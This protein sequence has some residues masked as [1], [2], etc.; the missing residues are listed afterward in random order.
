ME[1]NSQEIIKSHNTLLIIISISCLGCSLEGISQGWEMWVPPLL[2][3]AVIAAWWMHITQRGQVRSRENYYLYLSIFMGFFHGIHTDSFF[4]VVVVSSLLMGTFTLLKRVIYLRIILAEYVIVII[5]QIIMAAVTGNTIFDSLTISRLALHSGSILCIYSVLKKML[6]KSISDREEINKRDLD[7][8]A[9][10]HDMEDFL[11]NISH[12][13]R[14]PVNV[15]N[16]LSGLI[17]NREKR[18]DVKSIRNAGLRLARQIEDIQDYSEIQRKDLKIE[19]EKYMITSVLNDILSNYNDMEKI[20]KLDFVVDLDPIVPAAMRGDVNK[21]RK[22]IEHLLDNAFKFTKRGGVRLRISAIRKDYGVNLLIEVSDT[23]I[24]MSNK[25]IESVSNGL[26]QADKKRTRSTGGIGLGLSIVYGMIRNMDGFVRI[27][28]G[29]GKGTIVRISV[30]QEVVDSSPCMSV[31]TN[32]FLNVAYYT[33]PGTYR[34]AYMG[35]FYSDMARNLASGLR[36]NLYSAINLD[37]LKKLLSKGNITHVFMGANE[38]AKDA[39]YFD[40][41]AKGKVKV[42]I[43]APRDFKVSSDSNVITM[44]LPL[45]GYQIVQILNGEIDRG[46]ISYEAEI[47]KPVL[48]GVRALVVDDEPMNLVVAMGLLRE[49]K[50]LVDTAE[51][52][53]ESIE[54]FSN[55]DYD[56]ILMDHMMPEM[57]G[58]EAMKKI[59]SIAEQENRKVKLIAFTANAVSG[60]REMFMQE[61]FDGFISK[62]IKVHDFERVMAHVMSEKRSG[63][64]GGAR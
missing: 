40:E 29:K 52:G 25:D 20:H 39:G 42:A 7:R 43:S 6:Q 30:F 8:K 18:E 48:E 34:E 50:M 57:D 16:G 59:R 41:L 14:T 1:D 46:I 21:I 31:N 56:V 17:L 51:S 2:A 49:Y 24:G 5:I 47:E 28:S 63:W 26:Y 54:K 35:A 44:S 61:G 3:L 27:E 23:G 11:V 64:K 22:I 9:Y 4:D 55:N 62:P 45:Y 12:E 38:Y 15:I 60:A 36:V 58:V 19:N 10:D 37:E 13:L 33:I 32:R 53:K